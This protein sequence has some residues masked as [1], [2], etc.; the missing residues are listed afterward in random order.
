MDAASIITAARYQLSDT[1]GTP[2][3][4]DVRLLSILNECLVDLAVNTDLFNRVGYVALT[5][6]ATNFDISNVC[7]KLEDIEQAGRQLDI[8]TTEE[9]YKKRGDWRKLSSKYIEGIVIDN[10]P[11][12]FR[13]YPKYKSDTGLPEDLYGIVTDTNDIVTL[14]TDEDQAEELYGIT[15]ADFSADNYLKIKYTAMPQNVLELTDELTSEISHLLKLPMTYYISGMAY[16]DNMDEQ[17]VALGNQN[18][19]YYNSYVGGLTVARSSNYNN[20]LID[21]SFIGYG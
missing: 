21:T 15:D 9:L 5:N 7:F 12:R 8:L 4:S 14:L 3:W 16:R 17:S 2:R 19:Q 1:T 20:I 18:I 10:V 6:G 11:G 13:I